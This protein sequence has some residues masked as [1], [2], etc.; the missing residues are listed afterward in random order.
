MNPPFDITRAKL[1]SM[2]G[3][4]S[5]EAADAQWRLVLELRCVNSRFLDLAL[6]LPDE[7]RWAEGALREQLAAAV[8]RGK[9]ECRLAVRRERSDSAPTLNDSA[10]GAFA[11][12]Y[13]QL[14]RQVVGM[15]A[16]TIADVLAWPGV[17]ATDEADQD[18]QRKLLTQAA[19]V[20]LKQLG[21]SRA[22]EGRALAQV[23]AGKLHQMLDIIA[24][25]RTAL[26]QVL[27]Q[28]QAKISERMHAALGLVTDQQAATVSAEEIRE[29]IRQEVVM[30]GMRID[31]AEELDRLAGHCNQVLG[32]L[33][34]TEAVGKRLDFLIQE[35]HREANTLGSKMVSDA[36]SQASIDLKVLI[37]QLR[38]Q[39]QNIE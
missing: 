33:T 5:G 2:T 38:E 10:V 30:I 39:V 23:L 25:L 27:E 11:S 6:K 17:R 36:F 9:L 19:Q 18:Q 29:R 15:A 26:P 1:R 7:F 13:L 28:T 24:Q 21:E 4:G 8:A 34:S 16:P 37:E 20:A 31:V 14:S 3:F 35:M 22:R 32:L 12:A